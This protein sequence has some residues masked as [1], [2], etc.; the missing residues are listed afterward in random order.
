MEKVIDPVSLDLIQA[1]LTH[2]KKLCDTNKAGNEVYVFDWRDAPNTLR[3][4]GRL[5]E[6]A[7]RDS[8]GGTGLA[9]DLD[10][11]DTDPE[12][13]YK[14]IVIWDPDARAILGGYRFILGPDVQM[15]PDG[16]PHITSAHMFHY[17]EKFIRDYLPHTMELGRSFVAPEYQSSKAGAKAIF[18]LDNLWDGIAGVILQHPGI[19]YFLGKMTIYPDYD[20]SARELIQHFLWK[21]FPDPEELARPKRPVESVTDPRLLDLILRDEDFKPDYRNLK[22][23][24]RRLGVNIPPLVNSY[25]NTSPTMKMLGT[26]INDEFFDCYDTGIMVCYDEMYADKRERHREPYFRF[27]ARKMHIRFPGMRQ[28]EG[29]MAQRMS[30]KNEG[31][32]MKRFAAFL[33]RQKDTVVAAEKNLRKKVQ[34]NKKKEKEKVEP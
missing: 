32:R 13:P 34:R 12:Y 14:Q 21:H 15:Q 9:L 26:G 5:R 25:M 31:D 16:Q 18:A 6:L 24:I 17:S 4:V 33:N 3:E 8:G 22:D 23:A 10:D 19:M 20:R 30:A 2:D 27:L 1:E 7:F 28:E 11:F 29:E